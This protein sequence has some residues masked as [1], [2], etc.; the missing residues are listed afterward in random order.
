MAEAAAQTNSVPWVREIAPGVQHMDLVAPGIHCAGC[1]SRIEK[2]LGALP[3][4]TR[5]RV[6]L[7]TKRIAVDWQT[8][9]N[10][11]ETLIEA[12]EGLG[13]EARPFD[14]GMAGADQRDKTGRV[15]LRAMAVSGFAMANIMLLSVS[16]WSGADG[17]TRSLFHWLS[18][19]IALPA[20]AYAGRPFFVSAWNAVK[21]RS[22]NMD[23]PISLAVLLAA[24]MSVA[25]TIGEAEHAY[26]DAAVMLLFFLL[27]GRYL[28][29]LMRARA[30]SAVTQLLALSATAATV[31]DDDGA[32][33][34]VRVED[35]RPGMMVA[36]AAGENIPVDGT[37]MDG[38]SDV[39]RAMV[40]GESVPD[41]ITEG[42]A[43]HAGTLN[44][45]GPLL[46]QVTAAG[47]DTF[48]SEIVRLMEGAERG[49]GRY[50]RLA[51]RA[52]RAYAP[53][54]HTLAA[55]TF[56]GWMVW[57][58]GD[59][60][61]SLGIAI[62]VL[63]I[64]CPCA[65]GLAVPA[66]Q[67]VA[68]GVLFRRGVLLKDGAA[69]EKLAQVDTAI[70][71]KT[72]TLTAGQ[73]ELLGPVPAA[74]LALAAGLA[75]HSHHPLSKAV[76]RAAHDLGVTPCSVTGVEE[77][78]GQGLQGRW[79]GRS[80]RLGRAAWCG[81]PEASGTAL[82]LSLVVEGEAPQRLRFTDTLRPDASVTLD[83]FRDRNVSV[84][85][86]SGDTDGAVAA[87]AGDLRIDRYRAAQT[88]Q[89]KLGYIDRLSAEGRTVLMVGDGINDAPALAAGH[90][91]MAPATA[92]DVGRTAADLIF[93]GDRLAP[94]VDSLDVARMATRLIRQNFALA[95]AYNL[96]AVPIAVFGFVTPLIAAVAMSVSSLIVTGNA[97]RLRWIRLQAQEDAPAALAAQPVDKTKVAA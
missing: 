83:V 24:G 58:G 63:I 39:D 65:L 79:K 62:S 87:V 88:P 13:F 48:L 91:S 89:D 23:V 26:F 36:V 12:V 35:I 95:T 55:L 43:V 59:V 94:V 69:L 14:A 8:A 9:E 66:V 5:A 76:V 67:I 70:F 47:E 93:V 68:S 33:R 46:V 64:T 56:A 28:D 19:M 53:M 57:T 38:T 42:G 45:T 22:L 86:L 54:V 10:K 11:A 51:D 30:Q 44:L 29:H 3:G 92:S 4:V 60:Y 50:V 52:A 41:A 34:L 78:P 20:I 7:S 21:A 75:Q 80:V 74:D 71:D 2:T 96:I 49:K 31:V 73:A 1:V 77:V 82:S 72:G 37:V 27:I 15:L 61:M 18:A 40:T 6:N 84:E 81:M 32:R 25:Q 90:V 85:M 97:L 16:V 17:A